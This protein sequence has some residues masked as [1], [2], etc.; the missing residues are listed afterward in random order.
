MAH[1]IIPDYLPSSGSSI[2]HI[3]KVIVTMQQDIVSRNR[4]W[5]SLEASIPT[6]MP[7]SILILSK[8]HSSSQVLFWDS[9]SSA[10]SEIYFYLCLSIHYH[11]A[12]SWIPNC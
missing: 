4:T 12:P 3:Y 10:H 11:S 7:L 9:S 1:W 8:F 5:A 6:V 2:N